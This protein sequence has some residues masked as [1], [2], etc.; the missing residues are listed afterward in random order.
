MKR[1]IDPVGYL[2]ARNV[3]HRARQALWSYWPDRLAQSELREAGYGRVT[4]I[5]AECQQAYVCS[6]ER[7]T[8]VVVRGTDDATDVLRDLQGLFRAAVADYGRAHRGFVA[9]FQAIR[10][11]V[12]REVKRQEEQQARKLPRVLIGHSLGAAVAALLA[13]ELYPDWIYLFGCPRIGDRRFAFEFN[14]TFGGA[15]INVRNGTDG[16]PLLPFWNA[17]VGRQFVLHGKRVMLMPGLMRRAAWQAI[18]LGKL[19]W[20]TIR[21]R[22]ARLAFVA[23]HFM[24]SYVSHLEALCSG[25]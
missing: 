8:C 22:R 2:Q 15:T 25:D 24:E 17:P 10:E 11:H 9:A 5:D 13:T 23:D 16:V 7:E 21:G 6:N 4:Q 20:S 1:P 19:Y 12:T 14:A 3:V 18:A